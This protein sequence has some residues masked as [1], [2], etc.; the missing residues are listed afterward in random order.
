M[1][2]EFQVQ[3]HDLNAF[4]IVEREDTPL[5]DGQIRLKIDQ[6]SFTANNITY[7]AAGFVLKYWDF[8]PAADNAEDKWGVIPVWA[9]ADVI[10]SSCEEVPVGDRLYG[11]FPPAETVVMQPMKVGEN[12]FFDGSEHRQHLP[13]L[14]NRYSRVLAEPGYDKAHDAARVLLMPLHATSYCIFD[15]MEQ[16]NWYGAEQIVILS[17]SS[18]TSLGLAF[19]LSQSDAPT[20]IGMTSSRNKNFVEETGLYGATLTY[21][22]LDK[23]NANAPTMIVDMAGNDPLRARLKDRLGDQL[24][25]FIAVGITHWDERAEDPVFKKS[26]DGDRFEN[27]F[28]PSYILHRAKELGPGEFDKRSRAFLINSALATFK[29]M[30]LDERTS[31]DGLAEIYGDVCDGEL[32]PSSGVIVRM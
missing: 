23:L 24:T 31:L 20:V 28:A 18:K 16:K 19:A 2:K 27:F 3:K 6:F 5:Q 22:E 29:W 32:S 17:A 1:T 21:D 15:Q 9:F 14:Y 25:Y 10:E 30:S 4:R 26:T 11:Y 13:P 8:F 7:G 12:S